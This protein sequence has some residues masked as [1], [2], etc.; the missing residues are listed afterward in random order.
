MLRSKIVFQVSIQQ[1]TKIL[2]K[3]RPQET[4]LRRRK[5]FPSNTLKPVRWSR[6][7]SRQG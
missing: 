3:I 7:A 2:R 5:Y 4:W 6:Q 1:G